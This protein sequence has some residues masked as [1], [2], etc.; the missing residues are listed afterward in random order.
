MCGL[1]GTVGLS[2][3]AFACG[4]PTIA[5]RGPDFTGEWSEGDVT[6]GHHR[7]A[8]VDL[9]RRSHQ[10]FHYHHYAIIFNGE[11]YNHEELRRTHLADHTFTTT[12]DTETILHLYERYGRDMLP[13]LSGMFAFVIHDR[14]Q[15]TLFLARDHAGIKPLYYYV[16][17]GKLVCASEAKAILSVLAANGVHPDI[18]RDLLPAYFTF[19][20]IPS[21]DSLYAG[22]QKLPAGHSAIF[23]LEKRSLEMPVAFSVNVAPAPAT[24]EEAYALIEKKILSHLMA[25]VPVGLFFSGGTDSSLIAA[26]LQKHNIQLKTYSVRMTHKP[27]DA[28]YFEAISKQLSLTSQVVDFGVSEFD[29]LYEEITSKI[30]EPIHDT[31]LFPT[32]FI[33]RLAAKDV[34]VVLSGEGGDEFFLGYKRQKE[35]MRLAARTSPS[36]L[37]YVYRST[38]ELRGKNTLMLALSKKIDP[39]LYYLLATGISAHPKN[40]FAAYRKLL[41]NQPLEL[42]R[43]WYLENDL[44]KKLDIATSFASIE[45]RVP[46]VDSAV[47]AVAR[48]FENRAF[49]NGVSKALLKRMLARYIPQELVYRGKSGFSIAPTTLLTTSPILKE[50]VPVALNYLR[51][52]ECWPFP[53]GEQD[54]PMLRERFPYLLFAALFLYHALTNRPRV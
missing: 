46:L 26:V 34:K 6:L 50:R 15:K 39:Y 24:E 29:A 23:S 10:P 54:I 51:G 2:A 4:L 27:D 12:S 48:R 41:G 5:Y 31:S 17:D 19:G 37:S 43:T 13:L 42:D 3:Q 53:Y 8:I 9:D 25:D 11:I 32:Y 40:L 14:E 7:L 28:R 21:P 1:L 22:V 33:C 38:P 18:R 36:F 45:G 16:Q 49:D 20:Y 35:L 52:L 30:D 44:L 47:I